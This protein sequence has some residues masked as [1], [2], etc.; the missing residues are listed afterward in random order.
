MK[1]QRHMD[2]V[3]PSKPGPSAQPQPTR[4]PLP[5]KP[6]PQAGRP[7]ADIAAPKQKP[8]AH[9]APLTFRPYKPP[10]K[11]P[12][13][14]VEPTA[15]PTA[16]MPVPQAR[17]APPVVSKPTPPPVVH[18]A[19]KTHAVHT[20]PA[21]PISHTAVRAVK[22]RARAVRTP[23]W[24]YS[25]LAGVAL[26][27]FIVFRVPFAESLVLAYLVAAIILPIDS[28]WSF[29][30]AIGLLIL[31]PLLIFFKQTGPA[32]SYAVYSFYFLSIGV[33]S[34]IVEYRREEKA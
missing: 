4:R 20:A 23:T 15:M 25:V 13:R 26:V 17:P 8:L 12:V 34:A 16:I 10:E 9:M 32:E 14:A 7:I 31:Q 2:I 11:Q 18:H 33:L 22:P 28:K 6:T 29:L 24:R 30:V 5:V 27:A 1:Q 21:A 19:P 3:G